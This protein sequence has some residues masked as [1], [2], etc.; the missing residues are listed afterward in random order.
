MI[1]EAFQQA[2]GTISRKFGGTGLGL[3]ISREIA[4]LLGGEIHAE[5]QPGR[6]QHVHPVPALAARREGSA[7]PSAVEGDAAAEVRLEIAPG[8][9]PVTDDETVGARSSA[10]TG[11][12]SSR[13]P[14]RARDGRGRAGRAR[15]VQGPDDDRSLTTR[16]ARTQASAGRHRGRDGLPP[17]GRG[18]ARAPEERPETRHIPA[19]AVH[20]PGAGR[21]A[22]HGGGWPGAL[23][24]CRGPGDA[25]GAWTALIE[26]GPVRRPAQTRSLLVVTNER[27]RRRPRP[28]STLFGALPDVDTQVATNV[29]GRLLCAGRRGPSTAWCV[30]LEARRR[31]RLRRDQADAGAQAAARRSRWWSAPGRR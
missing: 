26:L 6:G 31:H 16:C 14:T 9:E 1:F 8:R 7:W 28:S 18:P 4:R 3:S 10:A 24:D 12:F 17:T 21:R 30:D 5:S 23:D 22:A 15:R 20:C 29:D 27:G 19:V 11:C 2:D 25:G 13:S